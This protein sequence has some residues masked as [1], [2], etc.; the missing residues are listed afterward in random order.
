MVIRR[1]S[2]LRAFLALVLFSTSGGGEQL[3]DALVFH[4][5]PVKD[6]G[7]R[8]NAGDHCHAEKCELGVSIS[9]PPP[10]APPDGD[11]RFEPPTRRATAITPADAPRATLVTA[12]LGSRAPPLQS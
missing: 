3:L 8:V 2:R 9:S 7:P 6:V 11:G 4:S 1:S 12:P 5:H 10:I